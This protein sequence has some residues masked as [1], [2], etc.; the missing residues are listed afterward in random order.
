MDHANEQIFLPRTGE[1]LDVAFTTAVADHSKTGNSADLPERVDYIRKSPVHLEHFTRLGGVPPSAVPLRSNKGTFG[2]EQ[3]FVARDVFLNGCLAAVIAGFLVPIQDD[4]RILHSHPQ[5]FVNEPF[6]T[7]ELGRPDSS[8][9]LA[10]FLESILFE[11][12]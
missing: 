6:V 8:S 11:R 10:C 3:I 12:P 1:E 9:G 4:S 7:A 2:G 5:E